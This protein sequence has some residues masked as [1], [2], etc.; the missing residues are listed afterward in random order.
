MD[1]NDEVK[2]DRSNGNLNPRVSVMCKLAEIEG[3]S[4]LRT[5]SQSKSPK[6]T[7]ASKGYYIT[8]IS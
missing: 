6:R 5:K 2:M 7:V 3:G 1:R 4:V 8:L